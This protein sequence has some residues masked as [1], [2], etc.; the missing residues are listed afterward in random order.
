MKIKYGP[1]IVVIIICS[2]LIG[3]LISSLRDF[4]DNRDFNTFLNDSI[5][6]KVNT[7]NGKWNKNTDDLILFLKKSKS[8]DLYF[9]RGVKL[10]SFTIRIKNEKGDSYKIS[11]FYNEYDEYVNLLIHDKNNCP[12]NLSLIKD[13][14]FNRLIS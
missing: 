3:E 9:E 13:E 7:I 11:F 4:V 5:S 14:V 2:L 1:I 6:L 12:I 8:S 10:K